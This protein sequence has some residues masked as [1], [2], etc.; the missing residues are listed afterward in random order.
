M[1]KNFVCLIGGVIAGIAMTLYT[2]S[3]LP[4][5]R[6][7]EEDYDDFFTLDGCK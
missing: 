3:K 7:D 5:P 4:I 2:A 1:N 6:T